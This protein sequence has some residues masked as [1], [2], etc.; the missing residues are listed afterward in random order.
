MIEIKDIF[1]EIKKELID[2]KIFL[3]SYQFYND[4]QMILNQEFKIKRD[5]KNNKIYLSSDLDILNIKENEYQNI[6][7][8][9]I[10]ISYR[11]DREENQMISIYYDDII[12][13][14]INIEFFNIK[15]IKEMIY[16]IIYKFIEKY[17]KSYELE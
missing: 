3:K 7:K 1:K 5:I 13:S 12:I 11:E 14:D 15:D 6:D 16:K 9:D 2:R 17:I 4:N 10:L 8:I